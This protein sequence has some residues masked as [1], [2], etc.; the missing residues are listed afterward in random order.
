MGDRT[1]NSMGDRIGRKGV[2][3]CSSTKNPIGP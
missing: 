2:K 1:E 3:R